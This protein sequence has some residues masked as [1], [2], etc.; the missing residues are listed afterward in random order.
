MEDHKATLVQTEREVYEQHS[1]GM[2]CDGCAD[3]RANEGQD[4]TGWHRRLAICA[5]SKPSL[6]DLGAAST[7]GMVCLSG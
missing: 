4:H 5:I 3:A 1:S 7:H 2:E 6:V